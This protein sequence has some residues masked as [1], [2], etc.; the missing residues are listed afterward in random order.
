MD[1]IAQLLQRIEEHPTQLWEGSRIYKRNA[2][3][4]SA[5]TVDSNLYFVESGTLR[6]CF[7]DEHEEHVIRLGYKNSFV[8]ALDS[9]ISDN[10][11]PFSIQT[12]KEC[13]INTMTKASYQDFISY[14]AENMALWQQINIG[15]IY[16]QLER[17]ID[18]LT[19][20]PTER[21]RRVLTRSPQLF[22]EIPA[23]HIASYL[24]MT[25]ETLSRIKKSEAVRSNKS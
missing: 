25:P 21:Y 16:Q 14:S 17:E 15:L 13:S 18:L 2:Y 3:V 23:K 7:V 1:L 6:V 24:K 4:K 12:I 10:P 8:A 22:Q 11:S 19:H 5:G 20:S 9:F